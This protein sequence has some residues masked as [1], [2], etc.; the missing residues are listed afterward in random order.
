MPPP[1]TSPTGLKTGALQEMATTAAIDDKKIKCV[2]VGDSRVGKKELINAL[3][4]SNPANKVNE[5]TLL[6]LFE[7]QI[8]TKKNE[9][10]KFLQP[11][12]KEDKKKLSLSNSKSKLSF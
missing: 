3:V 1:S 8:E 4:Q 11:N 5:N 6:L 2:V 7:N 9:L 10:E 12:L